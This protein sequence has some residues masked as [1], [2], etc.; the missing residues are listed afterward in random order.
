M[1]SLGCPAPARYVMLIDFWKGTWRV[2]EWVVGVRL[3]GVCTS[4]SRFAGPV[5]WGARR[6]LQVVVPRAD[7]GL[8]S[9]VL[10]GPAPTPRRAAV[11]VRC[12]EMWSRRAGEARGKDKQ[13]GRR[14]GMGRKF[15]HAVAQQK[16]ARRTCARACTLDAHQGTALSSS[17]PVPHASPGLKRSDGDT[18]PSM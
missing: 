8:F 3:S 5:A 13:R 14:G 7:R 2:G 10:D 6:Y 1:E 4:G 16:K 11:E 17:K 12:C 9:E 18:S 15:A